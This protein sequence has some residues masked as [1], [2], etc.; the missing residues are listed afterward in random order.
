MTGFD[1]LWLLGVV[2]VGTASAI[3]LR[4]SPS[5]GR[6]KLILGLGA[7]ERDNGRCSKSVISASR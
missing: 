6:E 4:R 2:A 7:P 3:A 5:F 1:A